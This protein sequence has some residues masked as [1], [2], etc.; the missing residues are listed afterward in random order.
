ME[1][2]SLWKLFGV[3]VKMGTFTIGGGYAMLPLVEQEMTSRGWISA[4]EV[5]DII[6]LAQS[7]PGILA[8]NMAIFTGHKIRGVKGSIAAAVGA[9]LP[10]LVIILLIA[11]CFTRFRENTVIRRIFQGI[12]P[13]AVALILV[14]AV[15]MAT[16]GCR[17]WWT[18]AIAV[19][20]LLGVAFLKI[21]PVWIVLT[22]ICVA[23]GTSLLRQ[24]K[25]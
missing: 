12:R 18:R 8:V 6:V 24:K 21:S 7:A 3:F 16:S 15:R 10:S 9:V 1:S 22:T 11:M 5:R 25:P 13:A 23:A 19:L 14:P 2:V 4:E 20:S 17:E